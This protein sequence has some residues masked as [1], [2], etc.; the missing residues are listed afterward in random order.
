[1]QDDLIQPHLT[2]EE[3]MRIAA[4]LKLGRELTDEQKLQ[5]VSVSVSLE[6]YKNSYIK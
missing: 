5:A 2:V 6:G 1:M 3:S 4:R